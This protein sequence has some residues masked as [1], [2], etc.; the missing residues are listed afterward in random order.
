MS[1]KKYLK[2]IRKERK[3]V[4]EARAK[5]QIAFRSAGSHSPIDV[6]IID[7]DFKII[8]MIQCKYEGFSEK[9]KQKILN[10]LKKLNGVYTCFFNVK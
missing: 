8:N 10:D 5:G 3:F 4:N 7:T 9:D 2:G 1:N 6:I